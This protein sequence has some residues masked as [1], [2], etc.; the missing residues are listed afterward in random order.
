[1]KTQIKLYGNSKV[2]ILSSEF[3]NYMGLEV[4]DWIDLDDIVKVNKK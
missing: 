2:L 4:G 3:I 1:M